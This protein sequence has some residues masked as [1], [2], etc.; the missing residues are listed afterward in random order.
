[1]PAGYPEPIV[2]HA[3]ERQEAL[4]RFATIKE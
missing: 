2:D 3:A 4:D 1:V